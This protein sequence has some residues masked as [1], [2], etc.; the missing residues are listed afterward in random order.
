MKIQ[1][2]VRPAPKSYGEVVTFARAVCAILAH[3]RRAAKVKLRERHQPYQAIAT[4][5]TSDFPA[6]A[7]SPIS[8]PIGALATG[9]TYEIVPREGSASSSPTIR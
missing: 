9:E 2:E 1:D 3:Q 7:V 8:L 5:S 6:R 4:S